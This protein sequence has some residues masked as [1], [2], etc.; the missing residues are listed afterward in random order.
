MR[1]PE[2]EV[3]YLGRVDDQLKVRGFRVEPQEIEN[4]LRAHPSVAAA[5]VV[6][7]DY[8]DGDVRLIAFVTMQPGRD[9]TLSDSGGLVPALARM[10]RELPAHLRPSAYHVLAALPMTAQGKVD[11]AAL[12]EWPDDAFVAEPVATIDPRAAV[13]QIVAEVLRQSAIGDQDDL[14]D[15]GATSLAVMRIVA[16]I[17]ELFHVSL[18]GAELAADA[19]I[20]Q[21]A[22]CA[23]SARADHSL[24]GR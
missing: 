17:N 13:R 21:L 24:K 5:A 1:T 23:E 22:A 12:R 4:C 7:H 9:V 18:T 14:F 20:A 2:G 16:R 6:A 8:G 10:A 3:V 19:T 15:R 11:R